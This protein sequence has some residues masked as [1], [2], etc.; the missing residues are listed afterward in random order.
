M[1]N[2]GRSTGLRRLANGETDQ[3]EFAGYITSGRFAADAKRLGIEP[4]RYAATLPDA[5]FLGRL[6]A[7]ARKTLEH[8]VSMLNDG[9]FPNMR[10]FHPAYAWGFDFEANGCDVLDAD[11]EEDL[12]S[13]VFSMATDGG[14]NHHCLQAD[15]KV[16]TW[17]HE[18]SNIEDHTQ[19][20]SLD[21]A[22]YALLHCQAVRTDAIP[23]D[24]VKAL[25]NE[26]AGDGDNGWAFLR[27]ELEAR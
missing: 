22:L 7:D 13:E 25:F 23:Y 4:L 11:F 17:N 21:E 10:V 3:M 5:D 2:R 20:P 12:S 19:F 14:G 6:P 16:V 24:E 26:K 15:G 8:I 1:A 27:A 9:T 18:E